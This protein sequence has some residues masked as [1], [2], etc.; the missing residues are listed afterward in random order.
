MPRSI[1]AAQHGRIVACCPPSSH[2]V[3]DVI[4]VHSWY[5]RCLA[6]YPS[7]T[8]T[9]ELKVKVVEM[10]QLLNDSRVLLKN[11]NRDPQPR[12]Q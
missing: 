3:P 11:S 5:R 2:R 7:Q 10:S 4:V 6:P 8:F 1:S 12:I 9:S